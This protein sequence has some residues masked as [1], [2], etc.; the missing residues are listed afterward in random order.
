MGKLIRSFFV[1]AQAVLIVSVVCVMMTSTKV[2]AAATTTY[3][4]LSF[5]AKPNGV[6]DS[7]EAFL[8]A[9]SAACGSM[10][11]VR[12]YVPKGRYLLRPLAFKGDRCKC[13]HLTFQ[14][15]GT[16]V[17]PLDYK[18]LGGAEN[19]LSFK[20]VSGLDII[21]GALDAKGPALWACK[22]ATGSCPDG[23]TVRK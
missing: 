22:A 16:L 10:Y 13:P 2:F 17:A 3:N 21:G 8:K 20:G 1:F 7:T 9:W 15:D 6:T 14:I 11:S 5:G 4:V 12:I 19:W 18:V 23:A